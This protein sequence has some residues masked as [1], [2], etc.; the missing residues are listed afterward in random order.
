MYIASNGLQIG[1]NKWLSSCEWCSVAQWEDSTIATVEI[2]HDDF[3]ILQCRAFAIDVC[4]NTEQIAGIINTN[5]NMIVERKI[6]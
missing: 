1:T 4:K 6:A 5:N 2:S 3:S